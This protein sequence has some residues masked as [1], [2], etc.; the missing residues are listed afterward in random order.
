MF[1]RVWLFRPRVGLEREF[2]AIYGENGEW[3]RLFQLGDGYRGTE[4]HRVADAPPQYRTIDRWESRAAWETF[5]ER[6][7]ALYE[8]LDERAARVTDLEQLIAETE[9]PSHDE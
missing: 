7:G 5:R 3:T 1:V 6:H 2:E 4:V 8:R 9:T